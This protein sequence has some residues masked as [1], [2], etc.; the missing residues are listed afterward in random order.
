MS[1]ERERLK[2]VM[3]A[4]ITADYTIV[5]GS[6]RQQI[7]RQ[8]NE[9]VSVNG[10]DLLRIC[11]LLLLLLSAPAHAAVSLPPDVRAAAMGGAGVVSASPASAGLFNPAL[12]LATSANTA[13]TTPQRRSPSG[14]VNPAATKPQTLRHWHLALGSGAAVADPDHLQEHVDATQTVLNA[15]DNNLATVNTLDIT[16][17]DPFPALVSLREQADRLILRLQEL[18][19]NTLHLGLGAVLA[20]GGGSGQSAFTL[21]LT[22]SSAVVAYPTIAPEDISLL[23]RYSTLL[24]DGVITSAEVSANA[25]LISGDNTDL[26][27]VD[28]E[29]R[30]TA[31]AIALNNS[32]LVFSWASSRFLNNDDLALGISPKVLHMETMEYTRP[33]RQFD[34]QDFLDNSLQ[35]SRNVFNLDL[36][37]AYKPANGFLHCGLSA[38]DVRPSRIETASGRE[39]I[40][41]PRYTAA[42]SLQRSRWQ[43]A[44]DYDLGVSRGMLPGSDTRFVSVGLE[45]QWKTIFWR[46]GHRQ[47]K[48]PDSDVADVMTAGLG[49]RFLDIAVMA[50]PDTQGASAQ[51][52]WRY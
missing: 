1:L 21:S 35:T 29:A 28:Y 47:N 27:V 6:C 20:G 48:V 49:Y 41:D 51:L 4:V 9:D 39:L 13:A 46:L 34:V 22:G 37:L 17:N 10:Q 16:P 31:T 50:G 44:V 3:S 2:K 8:D 40:L 30:T 52:A 23:Q 25:D 7:M 14:T 11:S 12:S 45:W 38:R 33:V 15:F 19:D 26:N 32:A 36:G 5:S 24:A 18:N 43:L 42:I